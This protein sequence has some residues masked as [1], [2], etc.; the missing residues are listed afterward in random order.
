MLPDCSNVS[1]GFKALSHCLEAQGEK[2]YERRSS[3]PPLHKIPQHS[4]NVHKAEPNEGLLL[5]LRDTLVQTLFGAH[6]LCCF[7][8]LNQLLF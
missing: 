1:V 3:P 8:L 5:L 4:L 2:R 6:A 7:V